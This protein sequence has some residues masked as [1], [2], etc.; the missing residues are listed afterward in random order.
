VTIEDGLYNDT[1]AALI[2]W[3]EDSVEGVNNAG[4]ATTD[5]LDASLTFVRV[6]RIGGQ[7]DGV[8]DAAVVDIDVFA[9]TR[10]T[11][12]VVAERI[13]AGLRPRTRAGAAI[14]DSVRT[15][16]SPRQLPWSNTKIKRYSATY[17]ITL[18]R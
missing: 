5:T 3:L 17:G 1:E 15:S 12:F 14:I 16:V 6:V 9:A 2:E 18:R 4:I 11:A 8:T 10:A 13:R 7:D